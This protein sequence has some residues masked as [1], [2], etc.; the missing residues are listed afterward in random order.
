MS[1]ILHI[2]QNRVFK[3]RITVL[4]GDDYYT[5]GE[6]EKIAFGVKRH[7]TDTGYVIYKELTSA[8]VSSDTHSYTLTLTSAETNVPYGCYYYD[9]ALVKANEQLHSIIGCT[10]LEVTKS[11]VRSVT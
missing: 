10:P 9:V 11:I 1:D 3:S 4:N 6:G 2:A 7:S 8:N 5:L